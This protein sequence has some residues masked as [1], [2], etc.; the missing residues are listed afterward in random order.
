MYLPI[1]HNGRLSMKCTFKTDDF[2]NSGDVEGFDF[3]TFIL[4]FRII[5]IYMRVN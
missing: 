5:L 3:Y 2:R 1:Q 4:D